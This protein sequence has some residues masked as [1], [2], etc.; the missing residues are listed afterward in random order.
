MIN[1][2]QTERLTIELLTLHDS[3]F[4]L[5]LLNTEGWLKFIGDRN[6]HS[7]EDAEKYIQRISDN[8]NYSYFVCKRKE[9]NTAA[10]VIT[11]I[12]R[13]YLEHHDI[14]FAFLPAYAK[15]GYA[16]EAA[17]EVLDELGKSGEHKKILA[18][19]LKDNIRSISLL[20]KLGLMFEREIVE[21]GEVLRVYEISF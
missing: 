1:I 12:K 14:G 6:V 17:K 16:Y 2:L 21:D 13:N 7:T 3:A 20:E 11:L 5:E 18:I 4:I 9:D 8:S 15:L 19:T 10:G